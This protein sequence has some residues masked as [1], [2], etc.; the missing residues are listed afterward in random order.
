LALA[1]RLTF[2]ENEMSNQSYTNPSLCWFCGQE[3][4][5]DR[6]AAAFKM[7]KKLSVTRAGTLVTTTWENRTIIIPRCRKCLV[8]AKKKNHGC[9][10]FGVI[11]CIFFAVTTFLILAFIDEQT[12]DRFFMI[13]TCY[14]VLPFFVLCGIAAFIFG[15]RGARKI[16]TRSIHDYPA[17]RELR[18]QGWRDEGE[19]S[20]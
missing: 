17:V 19:F 5:D 11:P 20:F 10:L 2:V 16:V 7:R 1:E 9:V 15:K 14:I 8:E 13:Y 12:S 3:P 4:K 18:R 6:C